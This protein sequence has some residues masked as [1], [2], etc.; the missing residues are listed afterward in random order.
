MAT[1]NL[2]EEALLVRLKAHA[3]LTAIVGQRIYPQAGEQDD[4][5]QGPFLVYFQKD[6]ED[7]GLSM[8]MAGEMYT[9]IFQVDVLSTSYEDVKLAEEVLTRQ[10]AVAASR[11]LQG[12]PEGYWVISGA[13]RVWVH[14]CTI[15]DNTD[16][17]AP[18]IFDDQK[19]LRAVSLNVLIVFTQ[20]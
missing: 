5:I 10:N 13:E 4:D 8:D 12:V 14:R 20:P 19:G 18:P 7:V 15:A 16:E 11:F 3:A 9:S 1:P 2:I 17:Y 6:R